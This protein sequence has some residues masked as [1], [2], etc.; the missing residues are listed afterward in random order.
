MQEVVKKLEMEDPTFEAGVLK[1]AR[2]ELTNPTVRE[3]TYEVE[4][5]LGA[6]KAA[7]SGVGSIT[8]GP[9]ASQ[10]VDFTLT[11]P[12]VEGEYHPYLDVLVDGALIAHYIATE[13]V[14]IMVSPVIEIGPITWV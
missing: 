7:T 1:T 13:T 4:L 14:E 10:L 11:M 5:Y 3:F 9:G 8:I 2:A 6:T 12:I